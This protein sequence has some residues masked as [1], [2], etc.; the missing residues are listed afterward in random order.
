LKTYTVNQHSPSQR[1]VNIWKNLDIKW[2]FN[3]SNNK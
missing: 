1:Q 2:I 3:N